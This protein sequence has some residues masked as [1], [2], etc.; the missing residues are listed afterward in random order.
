MKTKIFAICIVVC[1]A[2]MA[3]AGASLAYFTAEDSADNVFTMKG[4]KIK[5]EEAFEQNSSLIPG[6][7]INKDVFVTNTGT[8]DAFVRVHIAI[9]AVLDNG[10][11]HMGL[12]D[13]SVADGQWSWLPAYSE[14]T[15]YNSEDRN[16]YTAA[17]DGIN[18][19]VYVVTYRTALSADAKTVTQAIDKVCV[20]TNVDCKWDE[21]KE[22]FYYTDG[23]GNTAYPEQYADENG[24]VT[25]KVFAEAAQTVTFDNAYDALNTAFGTPGATDYVAP[26]NVRGAE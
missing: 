20:D 1:L 23:N 13:G 5:I 3:I 18:Y 2:V 22:C 12:A 21:A 6:L 25:I 10:F 15:G 17:I 11:I 14:G 24:N 8:A 7:D 16:S 26:W 9:P 4:I 19:N